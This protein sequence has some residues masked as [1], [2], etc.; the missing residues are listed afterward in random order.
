[1]LAAFDSW[2][3]RH[4]AAR[5]EAGT[6]SAV[7]DASDTYGTFALV[8][9]LLSWFWLGSHLLLLSAEVNVVAHRLWPRSLRGELVA[10]DRLALR[11][12]AEAVRRD[13]R[14]EIGVRFGER[15]PARPDLKGGAD[16]PAWTL[17]RL[18]AVAPDRPEDWATSH[19]EE[20]AHT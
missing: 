17:E 15:S 9:G 2:Q 8:I 19:F 10:A 3:R 13:E 14:Q 11:N 18:I 4:R 7:T 20:G 16:F 1:M 12:T 5:P 6:F